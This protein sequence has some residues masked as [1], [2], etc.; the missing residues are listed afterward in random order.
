MSRG[1]APCR[2]PHLRSSVLHVPSPVPFPLHAVD[3]DDDG[4]IAVVDQDQRSTP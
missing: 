3:G 4:L 1:L 2:R